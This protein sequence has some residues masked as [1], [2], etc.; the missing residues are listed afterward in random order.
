MKVTTE[1]DRITAFG[2]HLDPKACSGESIGVELISA[3]GLSSIVDAL[4]ALVTRGVTD[5]YYEDVYARLIASRRIDARA[6]DVGDLPWTEVDTPDDLSRA[7]EIARRTRL[8]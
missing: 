3:A 2:K 1:G 7:S 4:G 5:L 8:A 6:V